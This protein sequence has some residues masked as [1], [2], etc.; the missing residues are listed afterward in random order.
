MS[1][2]LNRRRFITSLAGAMAGFRVGTAVAQR[3]GGQPG[4]LDRLGVQLYTLRS[5]M[6]QSVSR[7][8][9]TVAKAGYREVEF[10]GFFDTPITEVRKM[11]DDNGLVAP[12]SHVTLDELRNN[13]DPLLDDANELGQRYLTVAW[14]NESERTNDGYA[15]VVQ[16]LNEAGERARRA[17]LL[18]AYHNHSYEFT[19]VGGDLPYAMLLRECDPRNLVMEA[20]IFW[21][22]KA[23]QNPLDWFARYPGR[24]HMLHMKDMGPPPTNAMVD[25]GKGIIDWREILDG[26]K[27]AGAR[28]IFVEH[29][30]PK[31]PVSSIRT[32]YRYLSSLNVDA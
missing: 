22:L 28:H 18:L 2:W 30:E 19:P 13:L 7:T 11:L 29:D 25:V 12:S 26:R 4:T 23:G 8:L 32:S 9:A 3:I 31:D 17:G 10:A 5:L 21:M 15:R 27:A 14:I 20:D 16:R 1:W 24:F 6:A